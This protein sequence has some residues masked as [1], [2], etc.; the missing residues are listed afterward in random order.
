MTYAQI[1]AHEMRN[2]SKSSEIVLHLIGCKSV[3][4]LDVWNYSKPRFKSLTHPKPLSSGE[5]LSRARATIP[6][7]SPNSRKT[8]RDNVLIINILRSFSMTPM[9]YFG[10][11]RKAI[12]LPLRE[13][14]MILRL[15]GENRRSHAIAP[16]PCERRR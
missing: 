10:S 2:P 11:W 3:T 12:G 5:G 4:L 1:Y 14:Q 8:Q 9:P 6:R 15:F 7:F 16:I 13:W